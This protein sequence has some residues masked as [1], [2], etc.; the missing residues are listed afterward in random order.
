VDD[1]QGQFHIPVS[2]A[3]VMVAND[4][5]CADR[6]GSNRDLGG[7]AG[8]NV[9]VDI[10]RFREEPVSAIFGR[11]NTTGCPALSVIVLGE[12]SNFFALISITCG[13]SFA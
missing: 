9:R 12:N 13:G 8:L 7:F 6:I 1:I 11:R 2:D 10:E 4:H 5:V 3:A